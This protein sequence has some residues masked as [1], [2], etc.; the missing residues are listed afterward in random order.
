MSRQVKPKLN[1]VRLMSSLFVATD[2]KTTS[3]KGI[4]YCGDV[5]YSSRLVCQCN[6]PVI[7]TGYCLGLVYFT[8]QPVGCTFSRL[9]DPDVKT[10]RLALKSYNRQLQTGRLKLPTVR[11]VFTTSLLVIKYSRDHHIWD[12]L[13]T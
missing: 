5:G 6:R 9:W 12:E 10:S 8:S 11:Y 3:L 2:L 13:D 1:E 7:V 4:K